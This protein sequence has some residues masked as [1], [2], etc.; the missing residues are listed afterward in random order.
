MRIP[1]EH[2]SAMPVFAL[3]PN[4]T[5]NDHD[6]NTSKRSSV[7]SIFDH[8][9]VGSAPSSPGQTRRAEGLATISGDVSSKAMDGNNGP[10]SLQPQQGSNGRAAGKYA[11]LPS[12]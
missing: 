11:T 8:N 5:N 6:S 2:F 9:S 7:P 10:M 3:S 1:L 12:K 4:P